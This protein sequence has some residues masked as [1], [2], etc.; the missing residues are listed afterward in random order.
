MNT[1]L[2]TIDMF[3][4]QIEAHQFVDTKYNQYNESLHT[5]GNQRFQHK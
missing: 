4:Q 2:M 1:V 3:F 5:F